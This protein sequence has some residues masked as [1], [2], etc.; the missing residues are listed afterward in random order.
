MVQSQ[1]WLLKGACVRGDASVQVLMLFCG[2][3]P[4]FMSFALSLTFAVI[5]LILL[6]LQN[7]INNTCRGEGMGTNHLYCEYVTCPAVDGVLNGTLV[8]NIFDLFY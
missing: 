2:T 1:P 4:F 3:V 6:P 8:A 5:T 7:G